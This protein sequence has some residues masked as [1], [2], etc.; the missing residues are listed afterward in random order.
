MKVLFNLFT[1]IGIAHLISVKK[2]S[3]VFKVIIS[4]HC[5]KSEAV[6]ST[7]CFNRVQAVRTKRIGNLIS[8]E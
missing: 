2:I 3:I 5:N 6:N 8:D 1:A 7:Q 4:T